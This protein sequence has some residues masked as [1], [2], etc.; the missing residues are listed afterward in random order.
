VVVIEGV[1]L[2]EAPGV[3]VTDGVAVIDGVVVGVGGPNSKS[4]SKK[5]GIH[6]EHL[7]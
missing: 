5:V 1:A 6:E 2:I 7:P 3:A 4:Q